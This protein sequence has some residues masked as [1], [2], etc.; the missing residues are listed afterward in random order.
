[1]EFLARILSGIAL[2]PRMTIFAT[3][4]NMDLFEAKY[5]DG[6]GPR[7]TMMHAALHWASLL[8]IPFFALVGLL[9]A[10]TEI[11]QHTFH[12]EDSPKPSRALVKAHADLSD[13]LNNGGDVGKCLSEV[14]RL[15]REQ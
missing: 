9:I 6:F 8:L 11:W 13:A 14:Q 7:T 3:N 10:V 15:E 4:A 12:G 5:I 2:V 1:M